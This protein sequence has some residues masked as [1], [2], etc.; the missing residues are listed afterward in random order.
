[1]KPT[2]FKKIIKRHS[3]VSYFGLKKVRGKYNLGGYIFPKKTEHKSIAI[4]NY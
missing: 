2:N 1:M 3:L 4:T